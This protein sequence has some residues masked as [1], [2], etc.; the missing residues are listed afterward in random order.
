MTRACVRHARPPFVPGRWKPL[1]A[2][3]DIP[4]SMNTTSRVLLSLYLS[5]L[6]PDATAES[7]VAPDV[8]PPAARFAE[9]CTGCHTPDPGL[10]ARRPF[11][12]KSDATEVATVI[13]QGRTTRG[14]PAFAAYSEADAIELARWLKLQTVGR[15][16]MIGRRIEAEDL[17]RD[18]S[19][20]YG[21]TE[22]GGVR[23]L[24][25]IDRG[26][27]LCYDD[28]DL[29]GVR[30]IEYRFAKGDGEPP[31]R[32]ALVAVAG[33]FAGGRFIPLGEKRTPLTGGWTTWRTERLGLDR[34]RAGPHRLCFI[35]MEGGGVFNFDHFTLSD[36]PGT[37]DGIT[38]SFTPTETAHRAGGHAFRLEKLAEI[39]GEFWSLDLLD[40]DTLI[41]TQ[42]SGELWLFRRGERIGPIR[43]T[44]RVRFAGQA[45]LL[46]VR[47][48]PDHGRN[49]WI[50]LTYAESL[51]DSDKAML[52]VARGRIRGDRWV[53]AEILWR[54]PERFYT[55]HLEHF[56]G[57]FAFDGDHL[58]F[59]VGERGVRMNAQDL[60]NPL[61][62]IHRIHADGRIP[63]DNP[64]VDVEGAWPT[65]WTLGH[66]NPQGIT[67]TANREVWSAEHGP[68]GGDELNLIQRGRNYGW[69]LVTHGTNYDNTPVS[70]HTERVGFEPPRTHWSPIGPAPSNLVKYE[71]GA[72]PRW[73]GHLLI[74]CLAFQQLKL[75]TL[76]GTRVT[77]E[78]LVLENSGRIRDVIVGP[79]DLPYVALNHPNGQIYRLRPLDD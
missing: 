41:A 25:F 65:I 71:G 43:D 38:Q 6:A 52:V 64:F 8:P 30:S 36:A 33:D 42:K 19:A 60:T 56:G 67:V 74:G 69:P 58:Y 61:G 35:G 49:G 72:F 20:G 2:L 45:G 18:R 4:A 32:F 24:Q 26:S 17:R 48:H 62:K 66:R 46:H 16:T 50:Y 40:A 47:V 78:E 11:V 55:A 1:T 34:Q 75:V 77:G 76:D 23:F 59:T 12:L 22:D 28:L 54:A 79:D 7:P 29:T 14:M 39:D 21:L 5:F 15:G 73:R 27:H 57:R 63:A 9:A 10:L 53:D 3:P 51:G 44:P 70:P 31:R 68:K 37:H 13:R